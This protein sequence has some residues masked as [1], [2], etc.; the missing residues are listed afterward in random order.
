MFLADFCDADD[1]N[2]VLGFMVAG[3]FTCPR[4]KI[5]GFVRGACF[6]RI[7]FMRSSTVIE[8]LAYPALFRITLRVDSSTYHRTAVRS[9]LESGE[10]IL[11]DVHNF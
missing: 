9:V 7:F 4:H 8:F 2:H 1:E 3:A 6:L 10:L 11:L 5:I